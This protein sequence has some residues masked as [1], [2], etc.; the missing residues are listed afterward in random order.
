MIEGAGG[1]DS[2]KAI[3]YFI[4]NCSVREAKGK[5]HAYGKRAW[6]RDEAGSEDEK[7]IF[8]RIVKEGIIIL[9]QEEVHFEK[10]IHRHIPNIISSHAFWRIMDIFTSKNNRIGIHKAGL[11]LEAIIAQL[12]ERARGLAGGG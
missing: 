6:Q 1:V 4:G 9:V 3:F 8:V 12:R 5:G 7:T 10:I 2:P 11:L